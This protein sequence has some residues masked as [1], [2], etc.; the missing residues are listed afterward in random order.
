MKLTKL[1]QVTVAA[2]ILAMQSGI[3]PA[4]AQSSDAL[5]N[6]LVEKGILTAKE[7]SD[8]KKEGKKNSPK[9][10]AA[11]LGAPEWV[12]RI[13]F[14]GDFRG[15]YDGS[16]R[17]VLMKAREAP[18]RTATVSGTACVTGDSGTGRSFRGWT[19]PWVR[20]NRL[21]GSVAGWQRL[22][23]EYHLE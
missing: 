15:R 12:E 11:K 23:R 1:T 18:L 7:A 8:L 10:F 4:A 22:L 5:L 20:R 6:K 16:G 19:A 3:H 9:D 14:G 21:R 2:G 17:I 13:K